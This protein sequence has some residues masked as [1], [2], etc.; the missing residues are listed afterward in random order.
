MKSVLVAGKA[1]MGPWGLRRL[2]EVRQR[3][4]ATPKP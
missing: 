2:A 3:A 1:G 4:G